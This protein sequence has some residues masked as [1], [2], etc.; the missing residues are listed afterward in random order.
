MTIP[1]GARVT[2]QRDF[3]ADMFGVRLG[4]YIEI[5]LD[6]K[7]RFNVNFSGGL[8]MA[9]VSGEFRYRES[10]TIQERAPCRV[11][12][13]ERTASSWWVAI[14]AGASLRLQQIVERLCRRLVSIS[15]R[16]FAEGR[17][18]RGRT[19]LQQILFMNVGFGF[20]F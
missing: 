8:A 13:P 19:R 12:V 15:P 17:W 10:T 5:P 18:S 16:L 2:G 7:N 11:P 9:V 1:G 20:S 3:N 14:L 4:P 6:K